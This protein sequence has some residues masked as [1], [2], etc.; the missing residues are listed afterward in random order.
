MRIAYQLD[1]RKAIFESEKTQLVIGR[2]RPGQSVDL[3]LSPDKSV[4]RSHARLWLEKEEYWIEDLGSAGGT[5]VV[6]ENIRG[7]GPRKI[8]V[9]A[10]FARR[11]CRMP[12]YRLTPPY[13]RELELR[14]A[15]MR[16]DWPCCWSYHC[17]SH[18]SRI[19]KTCWTPWSDAWW[20]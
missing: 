11:V 13:L 6:G 4:S 15:R 12:P 14:P 17:S 3:N 8:A 10:R 1:G 18:S 19:L 9:Q 16:S 2:P 20:R 7:K 5:L